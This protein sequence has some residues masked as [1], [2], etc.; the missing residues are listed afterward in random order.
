MFIDSCDRTANP[1]ASYA[2]GPGFKYLSGNRLL[3]MRAFV[4]FQ[5]PSKQMPRMP[6]IRPRQFPATSEIYCSLMNVCSCALQ[7]N[8][9][10]RRYVTTGIGRCDGGGT[11]D[12][13]RIWSTGGWAVGGGTALPVGRS[14]FRFPVVSLEFFIDNLTTFV[15]TIKHPKKRPLDYRC[16]LA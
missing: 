2:R 4:V 11:L 6:H 5:S 14:R 8:F 1:P 10:Q 15:C 9:W 16:R 13:V 7:P 12:Y 3:W